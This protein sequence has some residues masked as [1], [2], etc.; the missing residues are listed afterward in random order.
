M[1][2]N[3]GLVLQRNEI[4]QIGLVRPLKIMYLSDL[5]LKKQSRKL[6]ND[7]LFLIKENQPDLL[8]FGGDYADFPSGLKQ[9]DYLLQNL[10][11]IE[12]IVVIAGNH[13]YF[14]GIQKL[15]NIAAANQILFLENDC[16]VLKINNLSIFISN[17]KIATTDQKVNFKIL[18]L[19]KP[20]DVEPNVFDLIV[21]GHLHGG[22]VV[23]W[24][25][26]KGLF[27]ARFF[28][29]WNI[30]RKQIGNSLYLVSRGINDTLP[31][32]WNCPREVL[33]VEV[34]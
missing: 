17:N 15:K 29:K 7:L 1:L 6:C 32:R 14:L 12:H 34:I 30:L 22:Q 31:L 9:F 4:I 24:E 16:K 28:Y 5:H 20:V 2:G 25:N 27:P 13:D 33:I 10:K 11:F 19:H 23:F 3:F 18:C 21:A 8:L 26:E